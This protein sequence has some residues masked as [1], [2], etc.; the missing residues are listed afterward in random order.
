MSHTTDHN[1]SA[2]L[3]F[4]VDKTD[5]VNCEIFLHHLLYLLLT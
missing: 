1:I 3:R 2:Y 5:V 4:A